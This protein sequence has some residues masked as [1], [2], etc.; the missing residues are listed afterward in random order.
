MA[1]K[2]LQKQLAMAMQE[3]IEDTGS[4]LTKKMETLR[5]IINFA[6]SMSR[7]DSEV[8][9]SILSIRDEFS[10]LIKDNYSESFEDPEINNSTDEI[11]FRMCL[12]DI[13]GDVSRVINDEKLVP[14]WMMEQEEIPNSDD[15]SPEVV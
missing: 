3:M 2:V 1:G 14:A 9:K 8:G 15:D 10:T 7:L 13:H 6:L 4:T 12:E 11:L 5:Q